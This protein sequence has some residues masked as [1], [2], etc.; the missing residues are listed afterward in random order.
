MDYMKSEKMIIKPPIASLDVVCTYRVQYSENV[1]V[2]KMFDSR[3]QWP[4]CPTIKEIR[5]QGSCGS[6][7]VCNDATVA[8]VL[9]LL[10]SFFD[11]VHLMTLIA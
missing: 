3:E 8:Y 2:P 6:C 4:N 9:L 1:K 5:D 11:F 10:Y 7:W